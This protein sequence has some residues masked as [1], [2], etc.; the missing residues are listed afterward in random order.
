M[1]SFIWPRVR[2]MCLVISALSLSRNHYHHPIQ[3]VESGWNARFALLTTFYVVAGCHRFGNDGQ[4]SVVS[5]YSKYQ[6]SLIHPHNIWYTRIRVLAR[7]NNKKCVIG[8]WFIVP[9]Y[10]ADDLMI[11]TLHHEGSSINGNMGGNRHKNKPLR[12]IIWLQSKKCS[13]RPVSSTSSTTLMMIETIGNCTVFH[14]LPMR[15]RIQTR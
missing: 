5:Y 6:P 7:S 12:S 13:T 8:R 2:P 15:Q 11:D 14:R 3:V 4:P 10:G 1:L 9:V